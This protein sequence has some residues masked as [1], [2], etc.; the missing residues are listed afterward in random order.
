M[1]SVYFKDFKRV[2]DVLFTCAKFKVEHIYVRFYAIL[3]IGLSFTFNWLQEC[4]CNKSVWRMRPPFFVTGKTDS[5][6]S[7]LVKREFED[8]ALKV[9][10]S[11]SIGDFVKTF[12]TFNW[13]PFFG[14]C[15]DWFGHKFGYVLAPSSVDPL[16]GVNLFYQ[17][18]GGLQA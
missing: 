9:P 8:V 1:T 18:A 17:N 2:L 3:V 15:N 16:G 11:S 5:E 7:L 4:K 6:I 10:E 14:R 12:V 13:T